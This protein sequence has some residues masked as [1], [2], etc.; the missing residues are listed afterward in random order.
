MASP[1]ADA[2]DKLLNQKLVLEK[3][4][5]L[6]PNERIIFSST[7]FIVK[8]IRK[9]DRKKLGFPSVGN[10]H[11]G[12][13]VMS[14]KSLFFLNPKKTSFEQLMK[15]IWRFILIGTILIFLPFAVLFFIKRQ[16]K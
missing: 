6:H 10:H 8:R 16:P 9:G 3:F 7:G 4:K 13:I 2:N 5:E 12:G 11:I 14:N 1:F 15:W